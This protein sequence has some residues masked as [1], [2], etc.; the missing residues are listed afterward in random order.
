[1][2]RTMIDRECAVC[3][4]TFQVAPSRLKHGRGVHCSKECQY[5]A[6]REKLATGDRTTLVCIGCGNEFDRLNS[7]LK[8]GKG[9]GKF[10]SREC[11]D[12]HWKGELNPN[13]QDGSG[14]YKRGPH[15]HSIRR[16]VLKRDN[17]EC[18]EC[19]SKDDLHVHHKI[20][21]RMFEDADEA[22][23][24]SN[25]ITLC[26]PCHRKEDARH[27]WVRVSGS[28]IRMDAGSYAWELVR[29]MQKNGNFNY[30]E[31]A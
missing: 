12:E 5:I 11:R 28:I 14:V 24:E 23:H 30:G 22:N 15:W 10:C 4:A 29:A 21:F 6:N 26:P 9:M 1:M 27:K 31:V 19:G 18:Q 16:A 8:K 7:W 25:L 3:G 2:P 13:W 20:P 17:Y